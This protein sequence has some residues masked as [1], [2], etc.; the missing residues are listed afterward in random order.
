MP[1]KACARLVTQTCGS[2][3]QC[4]QTQACN[5]AHQLLVLE[6]QARLNNQETASA[7]DTQCADALL[8]PF[9]TVCQ[10]PVS[11]KSK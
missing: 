10:K 7:T 4:K 8:N 11:D 6:Q 1:D 5:A 2:Q 3:A 9:F